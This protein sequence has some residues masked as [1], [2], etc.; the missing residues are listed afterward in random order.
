MANPQLEDGYTPIANEILESLVRT[1]LSSNQ[2]RVLLCIIRRT[3]GF[4]KK[5]DYI[6]NRQIVEA[7]GLC[8]AVVSRALHDL[9]DLSL[10]VRTG[11]LIGF[12]KDWGKW[13]KLAEQSTL[14][15]TLAELQTTE[16]L[17]IPSTELAESSTKVS[18]PRVT[19]N[20]KDTYQDI[21]A[22]RGKSPESFEQYTERLRQR[23]TD[24]DFNLELEKFNLYWEGKGKLKNPKLALLNWMGRAR[25]FKQTEGGKGNGTKSD[26]GIPGNRPAGAFADLEN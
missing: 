20:I 9:N 21:S 7:T 24:L 4:H 8:K 23:F 17:A 1:H 25:K 5:V 2:W 19:Q 3:Y 26:R 6:A 11:K 10:I 13:G 14:S 15:T 16:K 18:S 12:Q 22:T